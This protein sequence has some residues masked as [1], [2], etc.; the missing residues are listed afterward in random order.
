MHS[1]GAGGLRERVVAAYGGEASWRQAR[2]VEATFSC[3][4]RLI[5]GKRGRE[6]PGI[7]A[8]AELGRPA[9]RLGRFEQPHLVGVL[10]GHDVRVE[11]TAGEVVES[12]SDARAP[13]PD[14]GERDDRWDRLD[15]LYFLG[16]AFWNYLT[17]PALLMREDIEWRELSETELAARFPPQLPTHCEEQRYHFDSETALLRE[18]DYTAEVIGPWAA[19]AHMI[20]E[21]GGQEGIPFPSR[22][23]VLARPRR[24]SGDPRDGVPMIE[25]EVHE[26]RLV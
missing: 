17:L 8:R 9:I 15:I 24:D 16:Y 11:S 7:E 26:H 6:Y 13:F 12:R 18:Y 4:G 10:E 1:A 20:L 21:H 25:I 14:E 19:A 22:R 23:H 2:A 3:G 5:R